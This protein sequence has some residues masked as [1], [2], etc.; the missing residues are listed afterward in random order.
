MHPCLKTDVFR[1]AINN[2]NLSGI[3]LVSRILNNHY[4]AVP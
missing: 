4:K 1:V 3:R 2:F